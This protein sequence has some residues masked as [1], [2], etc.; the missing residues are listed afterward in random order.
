MKSPLFAAIVTAAGNSRRMGGR[1]KEYLC[2]GKTGDGK[3]ITVLGAVVRTLIARIPLIAITVPLSAEAGE[4]AAR[5]ALGS[6]WADAWQGTSPPKLIFVPGGMSRRVS[7]FH[8]LNAL[9]PEAPDYV[10]IHDGARPWIDTGLIDSLMRAAPHY[11]AVLPV[12]P[13]TETPKELGDCG[14]IDRHLK[15]ATIALA[16]TPQAFAFADIL[17][18]HEL[19]EAESLAASPDSPPVEYTDD[20]EIW[21]KFIGTVKTVEGSKKNI[22]ITFPEDIAAMSASLGQR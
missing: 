8:A 6:D 15:R 13:V 14:Y 12:L 9:K 18:A 22:K 1:K 2:I 16:Q 20:A 10:L 17:R 7:V 5:A 19:A 4:T 3:D 21:G 11:K